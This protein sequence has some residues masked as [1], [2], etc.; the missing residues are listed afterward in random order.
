MRN[1]IYYSGTAPTTGSLIKKDDLMSSG[2]LDIAIHSV[3]ATFFLSHEMRRD[4][5]LHLVFDGPSDPTKHLLFAP[6]FSKKEN[7]NKIYLN[8]KD[9]ATIIKKMLYKYK[10]KEQNEVFPGYFI[11]K[12]PL[13]SVIRDLLSEGSTLYILDKSGEDIRDIKISEKPTFLVGDHEGLPKLQ[14]EL[15]RY[16][17]KVKKVSIGPNTYF[18]S[19]T[20]TVI[21]NELDRLGI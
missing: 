19:Q 8:K 18:A 13:V 6:I 16:K 10:P 11:E 9:I 3:I 14:K 2:R 1:F 15:K 17:N 5:N 20:I 12:K 21:N 4:V 7:P